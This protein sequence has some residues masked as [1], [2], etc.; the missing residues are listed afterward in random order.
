MFYYSST[1]LVKKWTVEKLV[2][3]DVVSRP[4]CST[5]VSQGPVV[6]ASVE[7]AGTEIKI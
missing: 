3:V 1:S 7:E 5:T 2:H 4:A 6:A